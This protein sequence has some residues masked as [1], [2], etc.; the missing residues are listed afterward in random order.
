MKFIKIFFLLVVIVQA[1][2]CKKFLE[3]QSQSEVV[4]KTV[5]ALNELLLGEGYGFYPFDAVTCD[6]DIAHTWENASKGDIFFQFT[7]Q[8]QDLPGYEL[9]V[10]AVD[11][12]KWYQVIQV[13]NTILEYIPRVKGTAAEK[14]YVKGQA[15][16]LR[17]YS[18]FHLVNMFAL[19]YPDK[20][21]NPATN[22]GVPLVTASGVSLEPVGRATVAQVYEQMVKDVT[23]GTLLLEKVNKTDPKGRINH[24]AGYLLASRIHLFMGNWQQCAD[25]A[26]NVLKYNSSLMD[27]NTWGAPNPL[28]KP[29]I[30]GS[31]VETIWEFGEMTKMS[32]G[33]DGNEFYSVSDELL[34]LFEPGDLRAT[35]YLTGNRYNKLAFP[36]STGSAMASFAFRVSEAYINRAEAYAQLFANGNG[37]AATLALNDLNTFRRHRFATA[38]Y[39]H[40]QTSSAQEL[41]G[42]VRKEKRLEFFRE[43]NIRWY[44]LKRYGMPEIRHQY[45][46][47]QN[48]AEVYVLKE[49]DP[50]YLRQIPNEAMRRNTALIQNP[51]LADRRIPE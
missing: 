45:Y 35:V 7:W 23:E 6:D 3:E 48:N 14:N 18:Y 47:D 30:G 2:S 50:M 31:N 51:A 4:P 33:L 34:S 16:L 11:W 28:T 37:Q 21:T 29:I 22:P 43:E 20:L 27:L 44:D 10:N 49:R 26:T 40:L 12:T 46:R 42:W 19:S 1:G 25:A 36:T 24:V 8:P 9:S 41:L 13:C 32:P 5:Q 15:L 39:Q 17:S 38:Q